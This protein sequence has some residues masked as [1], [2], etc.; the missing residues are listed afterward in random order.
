MAELYANWPAMSSVNKALTDRQPCYLIVEA[1][2]FLVNKHLVK[3][4]VVPAVALRNS[5]V[6]F[7]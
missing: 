5:T 7:Y 4:W 2:A 6:R 1:A 3:T